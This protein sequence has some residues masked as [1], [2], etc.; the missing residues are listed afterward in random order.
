ML[1]AFTF[2]H[3]CTFPLLSQ[4]L[5]QFCNVA[6]EALFDSTFEISPQILYWIKVWRVGWQLDQI[7]AFVV[8]PCVRSM[9]AMIPGVVVQVKPSTIRP[10]AK[11]P[12]LHE[13]IHGVSVQP[14]V[15]VTVEDSES[16]YSLTREAGSKANFRCKIGLALN[17]ELT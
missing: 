13:S 14:S 16:S 1:G 11:S 17:H 8:K 6:R 12:G 4:E 7:D 2:V 9:R 3:G 15:H 10:E 5:S